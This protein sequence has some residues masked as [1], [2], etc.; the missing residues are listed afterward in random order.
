[1]TAWDSSV[2]R[3]YDETGRLI[4]SLDTRVPDF[5]TP[6]VHEGKDPDAAV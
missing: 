5:T 6:A 3:V 2:G 1:M 4:D